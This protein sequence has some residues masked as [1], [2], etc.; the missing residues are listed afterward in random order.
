MIVRTV[1]FFG[2]LGL[3]GLTGIFIWQG[4]APLKAAFVAAGSGIVWIAAMHFVAMS[5]NARAWQI[6]MRPPDRPSTLFFLWLVWLR[7]AVNGLL[8]VARV[9]GEIVTAR[10]LMK[11][12]VKPASS[13]ASLMGDVTIGLLNQLFFTMTGI[14]LLATKTH[15]GSGIRDLILGAALFIPI[16]GVIILVQRI[17]LA[18]IMALVA[19][20]FLGAKMLALAG[21]TSILDDEV[22]AVYR[23]RLTVVS[24]SFWQL[25][26]SIAGA[27]EIWLSLYF[28]G[29]ETSFLNA[30][31]IES[32]IQAVNSTAFVVPAALGVQ[33]GSFIVIGSLLGLTPETSL[34]LALLRRVRDLTVFVPALAFWQWKLGRSFLG[35]KNPS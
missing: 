35:R 21:D 9:G 8:P 6:L 25:A 14:V 17:G 12:G 22:R 34:A 26:G 3:I 7:E 13:I 4:M 24:C 19:D 2:F 1:A 32:I 10:L 28:L 15:D 33:E 20:K 27:A 5:F 23:R 18:K 29:Q 31:I 30:F 16:V 11:R